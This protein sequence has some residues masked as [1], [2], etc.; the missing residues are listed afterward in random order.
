[1]ARH[2]KHRDDG[3]CPICKCEMDVIVSAY[4]DYPFIDGRKY[5]AICFVCASVPKTWENVKNYDDG[6]CI[7]KE[8]L[9]VFETFDPKRLCSIGEMMEDGFGKVESEKSIRAVKAAIRRGDT[10][11][12]CGIVRHCATLPPNY[13]QKWIGSENLTD[14]IEEDADMSK[15]KKHRQKKKKRKTEVAPQMVRASRKPPILVRE[16]EIRE[17]VTK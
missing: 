11:K 4:K 2:K 6:F 14:R 16:I 15:G 5:Q 8:Y 7:H 3:I 17:I 9:L 10:E 13:G 1:M 12:Q